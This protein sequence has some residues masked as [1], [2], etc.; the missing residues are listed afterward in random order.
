M[1]L[2]QQLLLPQSPREDTER[3]LMVYFANSTHLKRHY[4]FLNNTHPSLCPLA[5]SVVV[6]IVEARARARKLCKSQTA[7]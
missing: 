1:P 2:P 3:V 5:D 7:R 6:I 4:Q